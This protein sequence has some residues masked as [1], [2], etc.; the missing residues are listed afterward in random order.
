MTESLLQDLRYSLRTFT[1]SPRFTAFAIITLALG[2]GANTSM[3]SVVNAI[4]LRPLP[5]PDYEQLVY[6][7]E[8]NLNAGLRRGISSPANYLDWRERNT[9]FAEMSAW[10]TWFYTIGETGEPEQVWGVR[11]SSNFFNLIGIQ[12]HIGRTFLPSED[13]AGNNAVV[14][15]SYGLWQRRFGADPNLIGQS[16]KIDHQSFTVIGILPED[17]NL[18]GGQRQYDLWMP[19]VIDDSQLS[20]DDYSI[21]VFARLKPNVTIEQAQAEMSTIAGQLEQEYPVTN[22]GRGAQVIRL[23]DHQTEDLRPALLWLFA[24]VGLVLA[25]ACANLANLFLARASTRQKEFAVRSALGAGR[26]RIVRQMLIE[27]LLLSSAGGAAALLLAFVG[28]DALRT[29]LPSVGVGEIPRLNSIRLDQATLVF[30]LLISFITGILF[31][32]APAVLGSKVDLNSAL[33]EGGTKGGVAKKGRLSGFLIISETALATILLIGAGLM[34]RSFYR[35]IVVNPGFDASDVLTMQLWLPESKYS[36]ADHITEFYQK[37]LERLRSI[38]GVESA[39]AVNFLPLSGWGDILALTVPGPASSMPV[40]RLAAQYRLIDQDYFQTMRIPIIQG[41]VFGKQDVSGSAGVTIVNEKMAVQQWPNES[42]LG[43]NIEVTFSAARAPWRP[44]TGRTQLTVVGVVGNVKETALTQETG[45]QLYLP[46]S[47]H[48]SPL[49]RLAIRANNP[50]NLA[51]TIKQVILEVDKDQPVTEIKVMD[52]FIAESTSRSQS[53]LLLLG[54]FAA[55]ATT[56]S[57]LGI[58]SVISYW[59]LNRRR[60]IGIRRALGAQSN[61]VFRLV[62]GQGMKLTAIGMILGLLASIALTSLIEDLIFGVA[63]TDKVTFA[64]VSVLLPT[65]AFAACYIPARRAARVDPV[66]ALRCE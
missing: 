50:I 58:H 12:P 40:E 51:G 10:R 28:L 4:M 17:F 43:R 66:T 13:S 56:L 24:A 60:E 15:V 62:I 63:P 1:K 48:P 46:Y 33:K 3:F 45:P 36:N 6:V 26:W 16:V 64:A 57:A 38:S 41:R 35:L 49:M 11:T 59:V 31:G 14:V 8:N 19:F 44:R 2:I 20:R 18:F 22:R 55:L 42:A 25:I 53:H 21:L 61:D 65:V 39:S 30:T 47:Q 7:W 5:F 52:D 27:S 32:V 34:L 37:T 54:I 9:V 23:R 29:A